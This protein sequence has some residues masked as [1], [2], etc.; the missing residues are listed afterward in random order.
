MIGDKN[1]F[2][3]MTFRDHSIAV[4]EDDLGEKKELTV[5]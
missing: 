4:I 5:Q 1:S 3:L 2:D